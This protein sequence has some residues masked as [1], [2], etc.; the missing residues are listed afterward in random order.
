[1]S[2]G[3][4]GTTKICADGIKRWTGIYMLKGHIGLGM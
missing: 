1:M 3:D 2:S 4:Y